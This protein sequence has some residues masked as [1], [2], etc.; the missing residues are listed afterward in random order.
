MCSV[1]EPLTIVFWWELRIPLPIITHPYW[2]RI[3]I[4]YY[5]MTCQKLLFVGHIYFGGSMTQRLLRKYW[6]FH[7]TLFIYGSSQGVNQR[8]HMHLIYVSCKN[9]RS[10]NIADIL[11]TPVYRTLKTF[12]T[13]HTHFLDS[14][15]FV[16]LI[17]LA[18]V[19]WTSQKPLQNLLLAFANRS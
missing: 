5:Y 19:R 4:L 6:S 12:S 18:R 15:G 13:F 3:P 10:K 9:I 14:F 7:Y 8:G 11:F 1:N 17:V 16:K 2:T